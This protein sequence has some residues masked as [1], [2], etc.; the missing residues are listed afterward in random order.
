MCVSRQSQ[1][2]GSNPL[3]HPVPRT[4]FYPGL[5]KFAPL[6]YN[7]KDFR[8]ELFPVH[9]PLPGESPEDVAVLFRSRANF[10]RSISNGN[11]TDQEESD[12]EVEKEPIGN[13][14]INVTSQENDWSIPHLSWSSNLRFEGSVLK[15]LQG[16][17]ETLS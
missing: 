17:L 9:L 3:W 6:D 2:L 4:D 16:P 5:H 13:P 14:H 1:R 15:F 8:L 11:L 10:T 7:S 12:E